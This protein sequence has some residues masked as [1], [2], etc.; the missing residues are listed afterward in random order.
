MQTE[1]ALNAASYQ[2]CEERQIDSCYLIIRCTLKK[3]TWKFF[4]EVKKAMFI[5]FS[6]LLFLRLRQYLREY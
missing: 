3:A 2:L 4:F 6:E 1:L 5:Y